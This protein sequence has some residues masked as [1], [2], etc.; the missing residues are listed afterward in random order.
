[1]RTSPV[2]SLSLSRR[3]PLAACVASIFAL[4]APAAMATSTWFV[5]T[6]NEGVSN[7]DATHGSLRW[8]LDMTTQAQSGDTID[9]TGLNALNCATSKISLTTGDL[10]VPQDALTILGPGASALTIDASGIPEKLGQYYARVF[11]HQGTGQ[12]TIQNVTMTGGH[13]YHFGYYTVGGCIYSKGSVYLKHS[14]VSSCSTT[15]GNSTKSEGAGVYVK[16]DLTLKYSTLINNHAAGTARGGGARVLGSFVALYSTISNNTASG[17]GVGGGASVEGS[18]TV[19]ASTIS[20]NYSQASAGGFDASSGSPAG[21][22]FL[23][24]SSTISGNTANNVGGGLIVNSANVQFYNSTIAFNS[25]NSS[26]A[27]AAPGVRL[28]ASSGALA[29]IVQSTLMSNNTYG[30]V[31]NDLDHIGGNTVT[32][33][34]GDL[35]TAANNLIRVTTFLHSVLPSDTQFDTCPRLGMLRNNGGLTWTHALLSGSAAIDTGNDNGGLGNYDQ[36]GKAAT[37]GTLDYLRPSGGLDTTPDIGAYEVQQGDVVFN[38]GF[39][40]CPPLII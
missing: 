23:L 2:T 18:V 14:V 22:T 37:N 11:S 32:F 17:S 9:M 30:T 16:G 25:T 7:T 36:R 15:Q 35:A 29:V 28:N 8:A 39:D 10:V 26:A 5:D 24:A 33:N 21:N 6:C 40:D 31:E 13:N 20:G 34:G 19:G 38:T 27:G 1:M 3:T 12:L 4:S